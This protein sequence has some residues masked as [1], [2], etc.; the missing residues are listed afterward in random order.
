LTSFFEFSTRFQPFTFAIHLAFAHTI[1][2]LAYNLPPGTTR[3]G[4]TFSPYTEP[5]KS[6]YAFRLRDRLVEVDAQRRSKED[7]GFTYDSDD[8]VEFEDPPSTNDQLQ[9]AP[10]TEED[11]KCTPP[12]W[13]GLSNKERKRRLRKRAKRA[14]DAN[15]AHP[16]VK[17]VTAK[18]CTEAVPLKTYLD[19]ETLPVASSGWVGSRPA[20]VREE[21]TLEQLL[22]PEFHMKLVDWDGRYVYPLIKP[23]LLT[24]NTLPEPLAPLSTGRIA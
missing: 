10:T 13:D 8:D 22:G 18:R 23:C 11:S 16:H 9:G 2:D 14:G 19:P 24:N 6:H 15:P 21:Y 5:I 7:A 20:K 4:T 12:S 17:N 3:S 1:T